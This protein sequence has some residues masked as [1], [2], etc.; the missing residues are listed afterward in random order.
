MYLSAQVYLLHRRTVSALSATY[1]ALSSTTVMCEE[2]RMMGLNRPRRRTAA[3][4]A[5]GAPSAMMVAMY[6]SSRDSPRFSSAL[7]SAEAMVLA[8]DWAAD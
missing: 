7:A 8:T 1:C 5:M 4:G 3:N 2:R 6:I